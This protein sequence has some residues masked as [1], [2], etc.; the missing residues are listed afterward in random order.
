MYDQGKGYTNAIFC[1]STLRYA[2]VLEA[3]TTPEQRQEHLAEGWTYFQTI[4]PIVADAS[5]SAAQ[6]V[7]A[8]YNRNAGEAFPTSVT[9]Q[10]Y[11]ALNE[12]AVLQGLGVP[13][14][15]AVK[16]PPAQ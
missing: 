2:K 12:S 4:R 15:L 7:E 11:A 3:D 5:A 13:P 14:T 16:T 10:I 1:L 8:A 6:T 9:N